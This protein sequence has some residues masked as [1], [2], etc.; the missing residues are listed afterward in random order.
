MKITKNLT[1]HKIYIQII[2]IREK[3]GKVKNK[4]SGI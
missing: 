2:L 1:N 3:D 4:F